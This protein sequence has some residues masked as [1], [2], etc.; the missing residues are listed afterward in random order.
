[1]LG[2]LDLLKGDNTEE[3]SFYEKDGVKFVG[4]EDNP[5]LDDNG[6]PI[7]YDDYIGEMNANKGF[8]NDA[9]SSSNSLIGAGGDALTAFNLGDDTPSIGKGAAGGF[10][11]GVS[12]GGLLGG[13]LGAGVGVFGAAKQRGINEETE[14][15]NEM[16]MYE[17]SVVSPRSFELGGT[18]QKILGEDYTPIQAEKGDKGKEMLMLP[19]LD[20]VETFAEESHDDM[21]EDEVT[22][23]VPIGTEVFSSDDSRKVNLE[24]IKDDVL[25]YGLDH[26]TDSDGNTKVGAVKISD[27]LPSKGTKSYAELVKGVKR[28]YPTKHEKEKDIF[29]M[30]TNLENKTSRLP[31][32]QYL[33]MHQEAENLTEEGEEQEEGML[34]QF[35]MGG[36]A[37]GGKFAL[38]ANERNNSL[39]AKI[40]KMQTGGTAPHLLPGTIAYLKQMLSGSPTLPDIGLEE[41]D[42]TPDLEGMGPNMDDK[43]MQDYFFHLGRNMGGTEQGDS[44][45]GDS[46]QGDLE[47]KALSMIDDR[48][49]AM[50]DE[51]TL[52]ES[53]YDEY[54]DRQGSRN[55]GSAILQTASALAQNTGV[56]TPEV[57]T[58]FAKEMFPKISQTDVEMMKSPLRKNQRQ[59]LDMLRQSGVRGSQLPSILGSTQSKVLSQEAQIDQ[60]TKEYNRRQDAKYFQALQLAED[61]RNAF[62][63]EEINRE[64]DLS[65]QTIGRIGDVGQRAIDVDGMLD[66]QELW[67]ERALRGF[68][69][70]GMGKL[71][72][73]E[74]GIRT[75]AQKLNMLRKRLK[76]MEDTLQNTLEAEEINSER[77]LSRQTKG[78]TDDVEQRAIDDD[79]NLDSEERD[80]RTTAQK[81]DDVEQRA[82]DDDGNL[83]SEEPGAERASRGSYN[84]GTGNLDSE[85][86]GVR[87]MSQKLN[88]ARKRLKAAAENLEKTLAQDYD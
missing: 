69:N 47:Q 45:Q 41:F 62:E 32:L 86:L 9:N 42:L 59:L 74:L 61:K 83:D 20:L 78:R 17:S 34:P 70:E 15:E 81:T 56:E 72:S 55:F 29:A 6:E 21:D 4:T 51:R 24:D 33:M 37:G 14:F 12:R 84:E 28:D 3:V 85:E 88:M 64:R 8:A 58:R 46:E 39:L 82:I 19:N 25:G 30:D 76:D 77:D 68:Y 36:M 52:S 5:L 43:P 79:G 22:D 53:E 1:M 26:R 13:I 7:P 18:I 48:R 49:D 75:S 66:T 44:E 11:S 27:F 73:E 80:I 31:I 10:L 16:D 57:S 67:A 2:V 63:A 54:F 35:R 60:R 65:R 40:Q 50:E 71:D 87:T 38:N 23:V